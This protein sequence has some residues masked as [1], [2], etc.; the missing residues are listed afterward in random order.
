MERLQLLRQR[1]MRRL[2]DSLRRVSE[3]SAPRTSS[4]RLLLRIWTNDR[5]GI[6]DAACDSAHAGG[7]GLCSLVVRAV[8]AELKAL[9]KSS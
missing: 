5:A 7:S 2:E 1:S 6:R 3:R 9:K 8:P 4:L